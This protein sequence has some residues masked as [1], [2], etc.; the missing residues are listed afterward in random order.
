V[1][2][3]PLFLLLTWQEAVRGRLL[4]LDE[5]LRTAIAGRSIRPA[6]SPLGYFFADLGNVGV[7]LPVLGAALAFA[8]LRGRL[9]GQR[10][11][12]L[13]PLGYALAMVAVPLIVGPLKAAIG[14]GG[15][16]SLA[17]PPGYPGLFPSGH[18]ATA[19]LAYGAAAL[20]VLPWVRSRAAR[21]ALGGA[22][23]LGNLAVG[24]ALVY[25]GY[26]W[27]LDV[28]GSWCLCGVL[29]S[30]A[31]LVTGRARG[32]CAACGMAAGALAPGV[33][34]RGRGWCAG[35]GVRVGERPYAPPTAGTSKEAT[36]MPVMAV[37]RFERFFRV[38][39]ELDVDKS[40]L[41][42]YNDF[43]SEKLYDLLLIAEATAKANGRDVLAPWDLP[44]SKGLQESIHRFRDI[45]QEVELAPILQQLAT[46]PPMDR[47]PS[48]ETEARF[49]E[50]VG[51][52][53]LALAHTFKIIDPGVKNP[54][55]KHWER[56]IAIFDLLL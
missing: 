16:G 34:G 2:L 53:S 31:T 4:A 3:L 51:G 50:I 5:P 1:L 18:A 33:A 40:D 41:K 19:M 22:V 9:A 8:V 13:P 11:W 15:P 46:Y 29:L 55:T 49:P 32:R 24:V 17:L 44:I 27:P 36:P 12:W 43:I 45:D 26:H 42:R 7:A 38:A 25:C 52:L 23:V 20:L 56:A 47:A 48:E 28:A 54:Q 37:S 30:A 10:H 14:R 39:A 35:E 6:G 21:R